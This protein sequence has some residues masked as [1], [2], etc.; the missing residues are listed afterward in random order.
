MPD[1]NDE[2]LATLYDIKT[3]LAVVKV[4]VENTKE[5]TAEIKVQLVKQNGRVRRLENW[6]WYLGGA[7]VGAVGVMK[8]LG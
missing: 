2:M 5:D 1:K 7:M 6:R 3:D 8:W 4:H